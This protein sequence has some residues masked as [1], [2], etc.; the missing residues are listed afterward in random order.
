MNVTD[1]PHDGELNAALADLTSK[2]YSVSF[3]SA[4]V[5]GIFADLCAPSGRFLSTAA[6]TTPA[7]ALAGV[8]PLFDGRDATPNPRCETCGEMVGEFDGELQHWRIVRRVVETFAAG[9]VATPAG[10]Q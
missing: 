1:K 6:G 3:E 9:H 4:G 2:G 7:E 5:V 8:W 10:Q